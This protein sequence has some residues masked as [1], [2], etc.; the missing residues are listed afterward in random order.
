MFL[1]TAKARRA[2]SINGKIRNERK[3][4]KFIRFSSNTYSDSDQQIC[5]EKGKMRR[6]DIHNHLT[7]TLSRRPN[8][9]TTDQT[10][11]Q[12]STSIFINLTL[13]FLFSFFLRKYKA[14]MR[15]KKTSLKN[16]LLILYDYE[17]YYYY[18]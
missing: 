15:E 4:R 2:E 6:N 3:L 7:Q 12:R 18:Y 13:F 9:P 1:L 17:Y 14:K 8:E 5:K 11:V 10:S 16:D